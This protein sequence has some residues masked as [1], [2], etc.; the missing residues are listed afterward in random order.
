MCLGGEAERNKEYVV[1]LAGEGLT[2]VGIHTTFAPVRRS[3]R[4]A[5]YRLFDVD[6]KRDLLSISLSTFCSGCCCG[7]SVFRLCVC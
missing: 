3:L 1:S 7:G 2:P 5:V 6:F 4:C